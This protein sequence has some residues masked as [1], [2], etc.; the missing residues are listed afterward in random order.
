MDGEIPRLGKEVQIMLHSHLSV[1]GP[2]LAVYH[3][4]QPFSGWSTGLEIQAVYTLYL[5]YYLQSKQK[6][7]VF[8]KA[9]AV[10]FPQ[11]NEYRISCF[12]T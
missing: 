4:L 11:E 9:A 3:S 2:P 10:F 7:F 6:E 8:S 1:C 5:G 12:S